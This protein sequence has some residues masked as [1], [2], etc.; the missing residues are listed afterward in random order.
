AKILGR[1]SEARAVQQPPEAFREEV[2]QGWRAVLPACA[3]VLPLGLALGV[4]VVQTGFSWWWGPLIALFIFAGSLEFLMVGMLAA[5]APLS[6]IAVSALLVNFRHVF[7]AISFPLHRVHGRGWKVYSTY[8]LTDEVYAVTADPKAQTWSRTRIL[9]IQL[10]FQAVWVASVCAGGTARA[11]HSRL[12]R[13][14]RF[15]DHR[16][17]RRPEHR[18]VPRPQID[19]RDDPRPGMRPRRSAHRSR[20]HADRVRGP[21]CCCAHRFL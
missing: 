13:R 2:W 15:R 19:S 16:P 10:I 14:A 9:S 20:R 1:A 3:A 18:R 21:V 5:A 17:V 8:A 4:L 11:T 7:Y 6:Q 12:R